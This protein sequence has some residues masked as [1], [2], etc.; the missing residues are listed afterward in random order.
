MFQ[1]GA[2]FRSEAA[3]GH[4][5]NS[6][7]GTPLF[8]GELRAGQLTAIRRTMFSVFFVDPWRI[9]AETCNDLHLNA[10]KTLTMRQDLY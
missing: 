7:H 9:D 4:E 8:V 6:N 5:D 2:K 10:T 3:M 1:R